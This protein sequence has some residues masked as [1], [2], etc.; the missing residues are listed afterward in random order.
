MDF[1]HE[2]LDSCPDLLDNVMIVPDDA[3]TVAV[4]G[5]ERLSSIADVDH[6]LLP[7]PVCACFGGADELLAFGF[8]EGA[9]DDDC[10]FVC[11]FSERSLCEVDDGFGGCRGFTGEEGWWQGGG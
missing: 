10:V 8:G 11:V 5:H 9:V 4:V 2:M 7:F 6:C 1:W 3:P